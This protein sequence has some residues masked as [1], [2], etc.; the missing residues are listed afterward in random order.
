MAQL[1]LTEK[2]TLAE[3]SEFRGRVF[4]ALFAKANFHKGITPTNLKEYKQKTFAEPFLQGGANSKDI[5]AITRFWLANYNVE[6]DA[7]Q[8]DPV[9]LIGFGEDK[10]PYD[11]GL[12]DTEALDIVYNSLAGVIAG[13]QNEPL[14][15]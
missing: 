13:D 11:K 12:L 7:Q 5:F 10:I 2:N 1:T 14:P 3:S 8:G 9:V 15:S 4:Q 6:H